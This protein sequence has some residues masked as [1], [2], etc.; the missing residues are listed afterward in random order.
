MNSALTSQ[1]NAARINERLSFRS[2]ANERV[3]NTQLRASHLWQQ[4][5]S[6]YFQGWQ[7]LV[8]RFNRPS[9]YR[10]SD[11]TTLIKIDV[12]SGK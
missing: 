6:Y 3:G 1:A 5:A 7:E 11:N 4:F 9:K 12:A 10:T 8:Y 2:K